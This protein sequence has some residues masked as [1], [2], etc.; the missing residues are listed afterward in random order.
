MKYKAIS[1]GQLAE[2]AGVSSEVFRRWLL[3]D[4]E[5][6]REM[7]VSPYAKLLPPV[8]VKYICEKYCIILDWE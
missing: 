4:A 5:V 1:K 6:L 2:A 3:K 8:A 7:G